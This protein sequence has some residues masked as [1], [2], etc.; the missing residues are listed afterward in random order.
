MM[1]I[2]TLKGIQSVGTIVSWSRRTDILV[3]DRQVSYPLL[4][5]NNLSQLGVGVRAGKISLKKMY[6]LSKP[7]EIQQRK[8]EDL[9]NLETKLLTFYWWDQGEKGLV[10]TETRVTEFLS[11]WNKEELAV[12]LVILIH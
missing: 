6:I 7:D 1:A 4:S 9:N 5:D 12:A 10:W 11:P 2:L 8:L 3:V